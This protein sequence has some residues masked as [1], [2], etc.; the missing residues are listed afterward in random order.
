MQVATFTPFDYGAIVRPHC[1]VM[2]AP[3]AV[4]ILSRAAVSRG[5]GTSCGAMANA[6]V[7]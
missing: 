5:G 3:F 7:Q 2:A 1:S 4:F 6:S